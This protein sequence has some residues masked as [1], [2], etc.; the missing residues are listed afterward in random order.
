M[1][2]QAFR[3][4]SIDGGGVR[5]YLAAAI[6]AN[7]EDYLNSKL[8]ETLPLGQRFDLIVGTSA[9]GLIGLGLAL[10]RSAG[11][12]RALLLDL[13]PKVFGAGN[14]RSRLSRAT[15]PRYGDAALESELQAVFGAHT[16]ADLTTDACITSVSLIDA[17]PRLHK[18][19]Y[20]A[21]NAG[22]LDERLIDVAMATSAAPTYFPARNSKYSANLVDGGLAANNP[23]VIGVIDALQF[24]RPSKRGVHRPHLDVSGNSGPLLLSVGTGQ[25]GPLPYDYKRMTNGGW[26]NWMLPIHEIVLLSQAQLVHHQAKFLVGSKYLRIDPIL[27]VPVKL[28]DAAHFHELR[29][30]ADI[31]AECERFLKAYFLD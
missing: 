30:K 16:L 12:L 28:D 19:D 6:L 21:R 3:I 17:K 2:Q 5:G 25:P 15:K 26:L 27:N 10:G 31:D 20:F 18:T 11:E 14:R 9:G 24:E 8:N 23:S 29:N 4:L 1:T 7:I 22:R 13:V